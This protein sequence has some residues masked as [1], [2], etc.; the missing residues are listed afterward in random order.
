MLVNSLFRNA[1]G[2]PYTKQNHFGD[3]DNLQPSRAFLMQNVYFCVVSKFLIHDFSPK[4]DSDEKKSSPIDLDMNFVSDLVRRVHFNNRRAFQ[5]RAGVV[6]K[7]RD[8][9]GL[10]SKSAVFGILDNFL[11]HF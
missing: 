2:A 6:H 8:F 5:Y 10:V 9:Q 11:I 7:I 3:L 1:W 4:M